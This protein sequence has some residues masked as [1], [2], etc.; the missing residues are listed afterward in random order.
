M[1]GKIRDS[2]NVASEAVILSN[3]HTLFAIFGPARGQI[4][5]KTAEKYK[6]MRVLARRAG[7]PKRQVQAPNRQFQAPRRQIQAPNRQIQAPDPK[8]SKKMTKK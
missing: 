1:S 6:K 7:Y 2:T 5:G 3:S 4:Y 8:K